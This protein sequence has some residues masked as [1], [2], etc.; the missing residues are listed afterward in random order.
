MKHKDIFYIPPEQISGD[1]VIIK[2]AEFKHMTIVTRKKPK[3]I[4]HI[5]D[6]IGSE[7]VVMITRVDRNSAEGEICK[8]SR[9][10]GEPNFQ[11]TLAQA[12]PKGNKFD[13]VLEKCTEIGVSEFI[14]LIT[15][16]TAIK[17]SEGKRVRWQNIV[18]AAIKQCG[19]SVLPNIALPQTLHELIQCNK[20]YDFRLIAHPESNSQCLADSILGI[21]RQLAGL[22][23]FKSGIILV[24]PEAGFTDEEIYIAKSNLFTPFNLG[25]RRFRSETAGI[26]SCAIMM[27]IMENSTAFQQK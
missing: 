26:I 10:C 9:F 20:I 22:P 24:G 11:L 3:D 6:G 13:L 12:I 16:K 27:E 15:E 1:K 19:R 21:N 25:S 2:G 7:Y 8:R 14:P 17:G 18:I 4:I 5:V 23:R